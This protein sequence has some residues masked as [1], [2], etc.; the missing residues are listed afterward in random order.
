MDAR[1]R[2]LLNYL[3]AE[4]REP[5]Q[6]WF[7]GLHDGVARAKIRIRLNRVKEGNFGKHR[8]VGE[9]VIELKIDFG[10]GYRVYVREDGDQVILLCGGDTS[11]Q[12]ADIRRAKGF[13]RDYNAEED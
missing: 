8:D 7:R 12:D 9:G 3:T 2:T 11:T 1:P 5:F 6:E 4:K 13:G 10:P